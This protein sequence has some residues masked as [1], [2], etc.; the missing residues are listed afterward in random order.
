M[1]DQH[2]SD[3]LGAALRAAVAD[4]RA[5]AALRARV[6]A[7]R[8]ARRRPRP[9]RHPALGLA[10]AVAVFFCATLLVLGIGLIGGGQRTEGATLSHA[11]TAALR[12]TPGPAPAED[13]N[14]PVLV[15][16]GINGLRF[17]YWDDAFG[18][19]ATSARRDH[20]GTRAAMTVEYR[21]HGQ[22][23]GYTIVAGPALKLPADAQSVRRGSLTLAVLRHG[24]AVVV[25][26]RRA[27]HT[28][29]LASRD[30]TA[31]RLVQLAAWT[32]GGRIAGYGR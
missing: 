20:V 13:E 21:G 10:G 16:A 7:E 11:A 29:V 14:H 23:V 8:A 4:V 2:P 3:E 18:L 1:S 22:R 19:G 30:A 17:P 12:S 26:W 6:E 31:G 15:R 28:C 25:T 27:G 32:G 5:P 9:R 24:D